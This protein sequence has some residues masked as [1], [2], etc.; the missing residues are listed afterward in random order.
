MKKK[1]A[2][3]EISTKKYLLGANRLFNTPSSNPKVYPVPL[4]ASK[5]ESFAIIITKLSIL[6]DWGTSGLHLSNH[7]PPSLANCK[8]NQTNT[9]LIKFLVL[10]SRATYFHAV[11]KPHKPLPNYGGASLQLAK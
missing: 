9:R 3:S 5:R 4:E 6:D 8:Q 2:V 11:E 1:H 10:L 7:L